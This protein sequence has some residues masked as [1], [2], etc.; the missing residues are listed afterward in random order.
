MPKNGETITIKPKKFGICFSVSPEIKDEINL[1]S[2]H[3]MCAYNTLYSKLE[4]ERYILINEIK[5]DFREGN[6]HF[7]CTYPQC[8]NWDIEICE[9]QHPDYIK[10]NTTDDYIFTCKAIPRKYKEYK[11]YV[12]EMLRKEKGCVIVLPKRKIKSN[13]IQHKRKGKLIGEEVQQ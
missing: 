1:V 8:N 11:S 7:Y 6:I 10:F 12:E 4:K 5:E 3:K 13:P 2:Y 9:E